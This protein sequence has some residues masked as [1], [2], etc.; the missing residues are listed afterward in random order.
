MISN[1]KSRAEAEEDF[2][3]NLASGRHRG[4]GGRERHVGFWGDL[5]G[6]VV[7]LPYHRPMDGGTGTRLILRRLSPLELVPLFTGGWHAEER[8]AGRNGAQESTRDTSDDK[9]EAGDGNR[10][11]VRS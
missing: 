7:P 10:A 2:V 3:R 8:E 5:S 9:G 6:D 1:L 11:F 4:G